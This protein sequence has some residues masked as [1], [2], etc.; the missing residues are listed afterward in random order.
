MEKDSLKI[1]VRYLTWKL[2]F[3]LN[4][5]SV[6]V[7]NSFSYVNR[8]LIGLLIGFHVSLSA[9]RNAIVKCLTISKVG[10]YF[11]KL[12][13]SRVKYPD[14]GSNCPSRSNFHKW[15]RVSKTSLYFWKFFTKALNTVVFFFV[16][17]GFV[18]HNKSKIEEQDE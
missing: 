12:I 10:K 14:L 11:N 1:E 18:E 8:K 15:F 17:G 13:Y 16:K 7:V 6:V 3:F 4:I 2:E 5:L 9:L